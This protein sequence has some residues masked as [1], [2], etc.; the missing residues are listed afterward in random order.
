MRKV[1]EAGNLGEC[2]TKRVKEWKKTQRPM[3]IAYPR[4]LCR[5]V[6]RIYVKKCW[7]AKERTEHPDNMRQQKINLNQLTLADFGPNKTCFL[8]IHL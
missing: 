1:K 4:T 6:P 3:C 7:A 8:N 5:N 2:E